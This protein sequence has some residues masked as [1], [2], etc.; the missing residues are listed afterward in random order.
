[1]IAVPTGGRWGCSSTNVSITRLVP[2][3]QGNT[4]PFP[5]PL[6]SPLIPI[7]LLSLTLQAAWPPYP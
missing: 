7:S 1:M 6:L 4:S 5:L 3:L 2:Y